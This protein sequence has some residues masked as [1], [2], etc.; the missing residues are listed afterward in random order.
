MSTAPYTT[1]IVRF[2]LR[3]GITLDEAL[4]EIRHTV[5]VYQAE[6]ELVRKQISLDIEGGEGRSVYLWRDRAAAERF[7]ARAAEM[8]RAQTGF[9]PEV[10]LLDTYVVVDNDTG[11]AVFP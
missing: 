2:R 4:G 5:P 7:F 11:E 10:E 8:I 6:P 9:A 1:A 3:P